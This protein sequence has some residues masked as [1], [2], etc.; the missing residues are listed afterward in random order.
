MI[1]DTSE[2]RLPELSKTSGA[3]DDHVDVLLLGHLQDELT[4]GTTIPR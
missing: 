1:T 2:D 4:R 3:H